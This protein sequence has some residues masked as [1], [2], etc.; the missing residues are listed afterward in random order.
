MPTNQFKIK[1]KYRTDDIKPQKLHLEPMVL[2]ADLLLKRIKD[3]DFNGRFLADAFISAYCL[4]PF[5][6]SL[7]D[8]IKLDAEAFRL[9]HEILHIRHVKDWSDDSH[10]QIERRIKKI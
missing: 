6:H 2:E 4:T 10:Q 9:F 7:G 5:T 8:V 1:H 3:G